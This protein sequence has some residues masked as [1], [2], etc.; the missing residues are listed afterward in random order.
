[1]AFKVK[2]KFTDDKKY[3][4]CDLTVEQFKNFKELPMIDTCEILK[5]TKEYKEYQEKMQRAINL[6]VKNNSTHILRLSENV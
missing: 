6:A 3:Y 4:T 5:N 1:M 2:Y